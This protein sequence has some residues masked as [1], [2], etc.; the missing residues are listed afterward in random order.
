[1]IAWCL[2]KAK[3]PIATTSPTL[4]I[5]DFEFRDF[6]APSIVNIFW[7]EH[8]PWYVPVEQIPTFEGPYVKHDGAGKG[9][10]AGQ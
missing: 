1:V 2:D 4:A 5:N 6:K 8:A 3:I 9:Q 7:A 10:G